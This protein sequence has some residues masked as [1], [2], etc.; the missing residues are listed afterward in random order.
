M[1]MTE[2]YTACKKLLASYL[3]SSS[4]KTVGDFDMAYTIAIASK[5]Y[6]TE[7]GVK[8]ASISLVTTSEGD[9]KAEANYLSEG[10]NILSTTWLTIS[11]SC[12]PEEVEKGAADFALL[13]DRKIDSSYA[14][15]LYLGRKTET[16]V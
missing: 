6:N 2:E 11:L 15:S 5:D 1:Q 7:V 9:F 13:I 16:N 8:T 10:R 12:P 3:L 4:W 14:R